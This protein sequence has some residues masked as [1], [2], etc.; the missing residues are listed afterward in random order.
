MNILIKKERQNMKS[1]IT[2]EHIEEFNRILESEGSIIR[3]H[4]DRGTANIVLLN[5]Q[6]I[7]N[8][9]INPTSTF[10]KKLETFFSGKEIYD[11]SYNNTGSCFW[12]FE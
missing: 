7:K 3:L 10:Y 5:E 6:Y 1:A 9:I 2:M 4:L 8:F 12:K 11:L